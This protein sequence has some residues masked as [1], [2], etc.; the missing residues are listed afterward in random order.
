MSSNRQTW[1]VVLQVPE[2]T[3]WL[4]AHQFVKQFDHFAHMIPGSNKECRPTELHNIQ[5]WAE[6]N[7]L[8]LNCAKSCE[9]IFTDPKRQRQH[10]DPPPIPGILRRQ[11]LQML[12]VT[13]A[14]DFAVRVR[15]DCN[16]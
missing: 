12:A 8:G 5:S 2:H 14:N 10:D 11:K 7:S 1:R 15:A 9:V 16:L 4:H 13:L 6:E 3:C